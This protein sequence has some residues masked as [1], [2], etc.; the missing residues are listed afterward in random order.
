MNFRV[1]ILGK[2]ELLQRI[3]KFLLNTYA[4]MPWGFSVLPS[5]VHSD[6]NQL[7]KGQTATLTWN[8]SCY[9]GL[10]GKQHQKILFISNI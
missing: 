8:R 4:E 10:H 3:S 2:V 7:F 6:I 5:V 9:N 1:E